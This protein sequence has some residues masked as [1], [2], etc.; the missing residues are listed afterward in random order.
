MSTDWGIKDGVDTTWG[1]QE[2]GTS[3]SNTPSTGGNTTVLESD[4]TTSTSWN[5]TPPGPKEWGVN[6]AQPETSTTRTEE[7]DL[8][9]FVQHIPTG[10]ELFF[11][12]NYEHGIKT[13]G[14]TLHFNSF[15]FDAS[16]EPPDNA[17]LFNFDDKVKIYNTGAINIKH[18]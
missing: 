9:D 8:P 3:I 11:G 4:E 10:G 13:D 1:S 17:V 2:G 16:I 7:F 5:F 18:S 6:Q 14:T 12:D 15:Q